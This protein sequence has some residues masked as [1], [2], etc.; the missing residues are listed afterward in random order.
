MAAVSLLNTTINSANT[1]LVNQEAHTALQLLHR[2]SSDE[3]DDVDNDDEEEENEE[4]LE[5]EEVEE[6]E[7]ENGDDTL[8]T[9]N[10]NELV[11]HSLSSTNSSSSTSRPFEIGWGRG[12][13][14]MSIVI[15]LFLFFQKNQLNFRLHLIQHLLPNIGV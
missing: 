15:T 12:S 3:D 8:V 6:I 9:E 1:C 4:E 13:R 7:E 2:R 14:P 5:T 10:N 11:N